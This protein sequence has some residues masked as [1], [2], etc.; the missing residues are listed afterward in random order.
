MKPKKAKPIFKVGV[1]IIRPQKVF[2]NF[3]INFLAA[4]FGVTFL[5]DDQVSLPQGLRIGFGPIPVAGKQQHSILIHRVIE[6]ESVLP[7]SPLSSMFIRRLTF[8]AAMTGLRQS[9]TSIMV[10]LPISTALLEKDFSDNI[11]LRSARIGSLS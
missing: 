10:A 4:V 9:V 6:I 7:D 1:A 8:V 2:I 11:R 5:M 3:I